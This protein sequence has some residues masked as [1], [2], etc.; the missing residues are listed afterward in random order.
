[1]RDVAAKGQGV[2]RPKHIGVAAVAI[3]Q[4][5]GEQVDEF[6]TGM[7]KAR[8][9]FALVGQ[10]DEKRFEDFARAALRGQEVIRMSASGA[11]AHGFQ[12]LSG[13]AELGTA[14]VNAGAL[15]KLRR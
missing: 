2:A 11:A 1:M 12:P 9:D 8:K 13:A 14:V 15:D 6:N 7:L 5:T 3:V 4:N 10:R